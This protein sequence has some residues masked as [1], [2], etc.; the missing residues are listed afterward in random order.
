ME[1]FT[2]EMGL[3]KGQKREAGVCVSDINVYCKYICIPRKIQIYMYVYICT[4]MYV[5]MY[6][7]IYI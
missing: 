7:Y 3:G 4:Y 1:M 6:T 5:Y 2:L